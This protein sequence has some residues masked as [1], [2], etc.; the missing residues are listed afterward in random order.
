MRFIW[1]IL[2]RRAVNGDIEGHTHG[3]KRRCVTLECVCVSD[4]TPRHCNLQ[5][6]LIDTR[7]L[8]V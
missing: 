4:H 6:A 1:E 3:L 5:Q 2:G 8:S 7:P